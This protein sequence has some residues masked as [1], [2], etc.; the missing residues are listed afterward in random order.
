MRIRTGAALVVGL[1]VAMGG[2]LVG[3]RAADDPRL[4]AVVARVGQNEITV[5]SVEQRMKAM[6]DFQLATFGD[7]P[8][9]VRR[10]F[11]DQVMVKDAL[12]SEGAKSKKLE[13]DPFVRDQVD[14][15]LRKARLVSLKSEI[16]ITPADVAAFYADNLMRFVSPA[17]VAVFRILCATRDEA[18][19]VLS[20][21][22]SLGGLQRWNDLARE[23]SIDKATSFR[24]GNLGFLA[25]D[26]SSSEVSVKTDPALFAAANRVKD[27]ELV[28]EPV[29][30]GK[31]FAVIWR[32]GSTAPIKRTIDEEESAIRQVLVRKKLEDATAAL[33]K[34]LRDDR[35]VEE[36]PQLVDIVEVDPAGEV[37]PK[38]RPGVAPRRPFASPA[39]S[40]TPRGLR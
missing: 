24:G 19:A 35:K 5:E 6:P 40:A 21:A 30:E 14:Q 31:S 28:P 27:G 16:N 2:V 17:R 10:A 13:E 7:T 36:F 22:K 34:K 8:D 15:A 38:K 11:L 26:G 33:L 25:A 23:H 29:A 18:A 32:R 3:A 39:P 1:C 20:Q 9:K 37:G 4:Q 12:F